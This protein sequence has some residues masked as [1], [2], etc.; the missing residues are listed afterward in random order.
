M[1]PNKKSAEQPPG[2][3]DVGKMMAMA[4]AQEDMMIKEA[5]AS[6]RLD[7]ETMDCTKCRAAIE[8][9]TRQKILNEIEDAGY[10]DDNGD[11]NLTEHSLNELKKEWKIVK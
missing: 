11:W 5:R 4:A 10:I 6:Y 3:Y 8:R 1:K 9:G 2:V 7:G